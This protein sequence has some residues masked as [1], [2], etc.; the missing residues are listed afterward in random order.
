MSYY[1]PLLHIRRGHDSGP[2]VQVYISGVLSAFNE[3]SELQRSRLPVHIFHFSAKAGEQNLQETADYRPVCMVGKNEQG[4]RQIKWVIPL[5][6]G[7]KAMNRNETKIAER[8]KRQRQA[9]STK[10]T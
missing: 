4:N 6:N 7:E 5:L 2:C 3:F 8:L 9:W 1:L 10:V